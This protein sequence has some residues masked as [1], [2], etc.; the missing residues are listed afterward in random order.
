M[1]LDQRISTERFLLRPP[2]LNFQILLPLL[3]ANTK[4]DRNTRVHHLFSPDSVPLEIRPVKS[5]RLP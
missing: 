4:R 1:F 3:K 2:N 5:T